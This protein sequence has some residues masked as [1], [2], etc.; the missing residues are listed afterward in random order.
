MS[1]QELW[2]EI[3]SLAH[4]QVRDNVL[5][6]LVLQ[7]AAVEQDVVVVLVVLLAFEVVDDGQF[8][9]GVLEKDLNGNRGHEAPTH[10][11]GSQV[12]ILNLRSERD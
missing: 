4:V 8:R 9:R 11:H 2:V 5:V 7:H 1:L 6:S 3:V 12:H 10:R